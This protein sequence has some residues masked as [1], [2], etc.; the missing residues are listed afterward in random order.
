MA[1]D[2]LRDILLPG[3]TTVAR[4]VAGVVTGTTCQLHK[5]LAAMP[6][7]VQRRALD[8]LL[9]VPPG[10]RLTDLERWRKGPAPRGSGPS[11]VKYLDRAAEI[12]GVG[13]GRLGAEARVSG[14]CLADGAARR[15]DGGDRDSPAGRRPGPGRLARGAAR[16]LPGG[17]RV[18]EG[19]PGRDRVRAS[20]ARALPL[21]WPGVAVTLPR[22]AWA[23]GTAVKYRHTL[24]ALDAR[25]A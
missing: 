25:L 15:A 17:V 24:T 18:P 10:S 23:K 9:D 3:V 19:A 21:W 16:P 2:Y 1:R 11:L 14:G 13:L 4:L 20:A 6:D 7:P 12:S 8:Q 22:L 5:E